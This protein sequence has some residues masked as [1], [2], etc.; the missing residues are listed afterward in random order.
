MPAKRIFHGLW[1]VLLLLGLPSFATDAALHIGQPQ[2]GTVSSGKPQF[3]TLAL[4]AQDYTQIRLDPRGKKLAVIV[5]DPSGNKFRGG[6]LDSGESTF[7]FVADPSGPY[8][9]EISTSDIGEVSFAIKL[10]KIVDVQTRLAPLKPLY[11]SPRIRALKSSAGNTEAIDAFWKQIGKE[12]SPLIEPL[13]GDEK[14]MLV[15]FLWRGTPETRNVF[16]ARLPQAAGAPDDYFMEH[17]EGTSVWYKSVAVERTARFEYSLAPNAPRIHPV[18][19]GLDQ[20]AITMIAAAAQTDPL[21]P[22]VWRLAPQSL[23]LPKYQARSMVEMPDA[24]PQPWLAEKPGTPAG[25]IEKHQ[26]KSRVLDNEREVAVYVP[27]GYSRSHQPY[28]LLVLFD[29]I[30]YLGDQKQIV[31]VPTPTILDNLIAAER[32]PPMLALLVGNPPGARD[33]ELAC[34]PVFSDFLAAELLPWARVA[35]NITA[36]PQQI[37]VGGSSFG[38]LAAACAGLHHPEK[39]GNVLSQSGSFYWVPTKTGG[40]SDN[41]EPNW[42]VKQFIASPK[43]ALRFYLDV[44]NEDIDVSGGGNSTLLTTRTLRDVLRAKGYE[45][46]YQEFA[47]GHDYLSWRGTLADGLIALIG[48]VH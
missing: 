4:T 36:E 30:A 14:N 20:G 8:R 12:G 19:Q 45:V 26:F 10:E 17:L 32:V 3:F 33:R 29:E 37:V 47:G 1:L 43:L 48:N 24:P 44:G 18:I 42:M 9:L 15:T 2:E 28:P 11:E 27:A 35:Y 46:H 7:D 34:N 13:S 21:N 5:Y 16:V 23:D 22:K 40:K 39:F 38:G 31:L 41:S 6:E 25:T